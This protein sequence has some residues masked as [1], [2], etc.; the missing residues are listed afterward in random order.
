MKSFLRDNK[1]QMLFLKIYSKSSYAK[2]IITNIKGKSYKFSDAN[3]NKAVKDLDI[4]LNKGLM[5]SNEEI[6]N[7][8][9]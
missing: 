6:T 4:S 3:I 2:S 9:Y 5:I 8:L 1:N 7:Y